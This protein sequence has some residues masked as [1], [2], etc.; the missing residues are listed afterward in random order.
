MCFLFQ[1]EIELYRK[2]FVEKRRIK[3]ERGRKE[4][5]RERGREKETERK[6]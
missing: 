1:M 2:K 5:D 4:R 6:P 3:V